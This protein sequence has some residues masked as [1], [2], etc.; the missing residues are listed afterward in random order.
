MDRSWFG[1]RGLTNTNLTS[2]FGQPYGGNKRVTS[3]QTILR[4]TAMQLDKDQIISFIKEHGDADKVDS[5]KQE[6]PEKVDTDQHG[7]LLAKYGVNPQDLVGKLGG[8]I[9][10]LTG[11]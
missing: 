10:G 6:L 9:G 2:R 7:D 8:G 4:R 3:V 11:H 5:A 1:D